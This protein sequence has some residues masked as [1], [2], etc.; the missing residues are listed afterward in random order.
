LLF[1]LDSIMLLQYRSEG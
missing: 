1:K